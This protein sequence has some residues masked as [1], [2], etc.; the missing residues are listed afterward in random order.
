M[1]KNYQHVGLH[2]KKFDDF[3]LEKIDLLDKKD[4]QGIF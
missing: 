1:T 4:R 2:R 3:T